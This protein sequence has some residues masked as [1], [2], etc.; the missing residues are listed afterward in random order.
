M[1]IKGKWNKNIYKVIKPIGAGNFGKVYKAINLDGNIIAIKISKDI[2]SITNEYNAMIK[3]KSMPFVPK[4]YDFDDWEFDGETQHFIV[5]DY[6]EGKNLKEISYNKKLNSKVIFKIGKVL[7]TI[8]RKINKLGYKYT[9]I[10]LENIIVSKKGYIYFIDF[11]SLVEK[12]KPTKEYSP[13]YNINSWNVKFNYNYDIGVLFSVTMIM[14]VLIGQ[15][16]YNP[17]IMDLEQII[18]KI[19][20][21]SLRKEDKKFLIKGLKG[22]FRSFNEYN[23]SLSVLLSERKCYNGL[24]RIDYL[25]IISIVSFIFVIIIGIKSIFC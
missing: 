8:L 20:N 1:I 15:K 25:L 18:D 14:V 7:I 19:S 23:N 3:L 9:D 5:M 11:G 17:L 16:E 10:K 22:E 6:I 13:N 24:S 21:F 4:L 2:L 12:D